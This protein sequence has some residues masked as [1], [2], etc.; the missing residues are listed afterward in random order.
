MTTGFFS[1]LDRGVQVFLRYLCLLLFI[2]LALILATN[3]LMRL[4]NDLSIFLDV[5]G[6][7]A[8]GAV[9]KALVPIAS[10]HWFDEIVELCFAALVF[11][12]AAALWGTKGHFC[13]GDWISPR[14]PGPR[15][16]AFYKL[17]VSLLSVAFIGTF[18]WY[19]LS[20]ALKTGELSTVFQIPKGLMYSCMPIASGIMLAY[21]LGDVVGDVRQLL[22]PTEENRAGAGP[23]SM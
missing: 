7:K 20:L 13:V 16:R 4:M 6:F 18:F 3:V 5:K 11:Y 14:L 9:V 8:A 19:S 2:A 21:S 15:S 10:M 23:Q 17:L 12:G 22:N 1:R